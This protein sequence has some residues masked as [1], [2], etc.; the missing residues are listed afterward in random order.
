MTLNQVGQGR[1]IY[2]AVPI[3]RAIAQ[4]DPWATPAPARS[5]LREVYGSVAR[6]AG[7]GAPLDCSEPGVEL[8]LFQG[9]KE[10]VLVVINHEPRKLSADLVFDRRV[11]S[12]CDV[13]G[14]ASVAVGGLRFTTQLA[15]NGIVALR[16]S[17]V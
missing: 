7:C 13:R 8:A 16:I 9:D 2:M 5:L 11:V 3:E 6:G 12:I 4:G 1:A 15:A 10:D 17:Y 14:G